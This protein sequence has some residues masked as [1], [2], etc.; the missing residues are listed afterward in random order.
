L[1]KDLK[2]IENLLA[3][4]VATVVA[5]AQPY[6]QQHNQTLS[7]GQTRCLTDAIYY[8]SRGEGTIGM[9]AV[10][11]TVLNRTVARDRSI[12]SVIHE[13]SQFSFYAPHHMRHAHEA[14][15]WIQAAFI[16][17]Y[18]QL[19]VIANPVGNATQYNT[20][21]MPGWRTS[22][23]SKKID[24]HYFYI[25]KDDL[26]EPPLFS[27]GAL[28][29]PIASLPAACLLWDPRCDLI[30]AEAEI[31]IDPRLVALV[32][33]AADQTAVEEHVVSRKSVR[34]LTALKPDRRNCASRD[35]RVLSHT[36]SHATEVASVRRDHHNHMKRFASR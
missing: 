18:T 20:T 26:H 10:A 30:H 28:H 9:T 24:H 3:A 29:F 6:A 21:K 31:A 32:E 2:V 11:Y 16:A 34:R 27:P 12:C 33:P 19:G 4:F 5:W 36:V 25:L 1:L 35:Y 7:V 17:A 8:E 23:L 22:V 13:P 14:E 15:S